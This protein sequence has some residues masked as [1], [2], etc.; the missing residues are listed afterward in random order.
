MTCDS[1]KKLIPLYSY[2]EL[3]AEEEELV[4][5]HLHLCVA[6]AREI[7]RQRAIAA[8]V[9]RAE[10]GVSPRLLEDCRRDLMMA[11]YR[12]DSPAISAASSTRPVRDVFAEIWAALTRM[13]QPIA[14]VALV[15]VGFFAARLTS[16]RPG[17]AIPTP[18]EQVFAS[19][20]SV[21]PQDDGGVRIAFDETRRRVISGSAHDDHIR[22][23]LL[24][25][26]RDE[27]NPAVRVESMDL[28]RSFGESREIRGALLNAV[29]H[30]PNP[31]VRLKALEGLKPVADDPG[32]RDILGHVLLTDDNPAVRMQ[33]VDLLVEYRD[34]TMVGVF[35]D[36]VQKEENSYVRLKCEKA[37]KDMNASIGT[38]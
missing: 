19:V 32:V 17:S 13:R 29:A 31:G 33:A 25:A 2:G 14:A 3:I 12:G 21:Q 23:L 36:L 37:L 6:C 15:L 1:V 8:A 26:A 16:S 18:A 34:H 4:E 28:L 7:E 35:Q 5:E 20:R 38:F 27:N 9:D 24:A 22:R 11:I 30:D 10:A